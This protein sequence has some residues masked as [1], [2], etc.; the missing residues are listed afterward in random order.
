MPTHPASDARST[1]A[2]TRRTPIVLA[3]SGGK[4]SAWA[5]HELDARDDVEVVALLTTVDA[6]DGH[7]PMQ[8]IAGDVLRA[9]AALTGRPL[10]A[11]PLA[12]G[13]GNDAYAAAFADGLQQ[14]RARVPGVSDIAFGDLFL[15]DIRQ[16]REALCARLGWTAHFPLFGR[17][18]A[19]LAHR[20]I[21][22]GLRAVVTSV[23]TTRL[24]AA[25]SG[26][27]FDHALL[28][29]LPVGI[30][31]CGENG[32]FHTLVVDGPMLASPLA[33]VP[34]GTTRVDGRFETT[35]FALA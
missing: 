3:W 19:A 29:A 31:P 24:D 15:G 18:T 33:V 1:A 28:V 34:A 13:A 12:A 8:G 16:W 30:D 26:R 23:D 10:V 22:G 14:A 27:A 4:D 5:L 9:Q 25:F 2:P 21:D 11:V 6:A 32:E 7:V 35:R 17:D 20:M